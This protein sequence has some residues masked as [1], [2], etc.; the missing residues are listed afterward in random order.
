MGV[1]QLLAGH[2]K[3]QAVPVYIDGAYKIM[4]KG[5]K[6]PGAGKLKVRFGRPIS[7]HELTQ[8]TDSFRKIAERLRHEVVDLS[9][10][11]LH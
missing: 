10:G 11:R 6:R 7:F 1:G 8:D 2:P 9:A 5:S 4:P 3:A